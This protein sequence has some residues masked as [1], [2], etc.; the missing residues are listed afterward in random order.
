MVLTRLWDVTSKG[1]EVIASG[2]THDS[3]TATSPDRPQ[4]SSLNRTIDTSTTNSNIPSASQSPHTFTMTSNSPDS[5]WN[6][7]STMQSMYN[8]ATSMSSM[9]S[10]LY[11][12]NTPSTPNNERIDDHNTTSFSMGYNLLNSMTSPF[13]SNPLQTVY[14]SSPMENDFF[15]EDDNDD[16]NAT[17]Q[18]EEQYRSTRNHQ[19]N[20]NRSQKAS[21][22]T[23][24]S[25]TPY[26]DLVWMFRHDKNPY[27]AVRGRDIERHRT[28]MTAIRS[29]VALVPTTTNKSCTNPKKT[30]QPSSS[31]VSHT[32]HLGD[33]TDSD[34]TS[35]DVPTVPKTKGTTSQES[36]T[37][38]HNNQQQADPS[39]V[40][41]QHNTTYT[42][43]NTAS[44]P[45][46]RQEQQQ[47]RQTVSASETASQL[48]EG[49]IRALRDMALDEAV[50][51]QIA[52][53]YWNLRWER[54]LL[55]WL[56]AGPFGK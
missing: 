7:Y 40:R 31:T 53:R 48:A 42:T 14:D 50:E 35:Q 34:P 25:K 21:T 46:T 19:Q 29:L 55:S 17:I 4:S 20:L 45:S 37:I 27:N 9:F 52:L 43:Y 16:D 11:R 10:F 56:E 23:T 18:W 39:Y 2:G 24:W 6:S 5:Y 22:A 47:R 15:L 3:T 1:S 28:S 44:A 8:A 12:G 32:S 36:T 33:E 26:A 13:F 41:N 51:L 38:I 54:P 30:I 49:T